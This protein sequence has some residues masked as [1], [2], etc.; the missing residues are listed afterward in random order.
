[1]VERILKLIEERGITAYK[2]A[3]DV[4]LDSVV[5]SHWKKGKA[6]P[7]TDAIVKI[8]KYFGVTADWLLTGEGP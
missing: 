4:G 3:I 7:S 2:L 6:K 1:M 8:A 5:I